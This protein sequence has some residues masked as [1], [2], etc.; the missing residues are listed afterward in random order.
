MSD[1]NF[2]FGDY[3]FNYYQQI[4]VEHESVSTTSEVQTY[5]GIL[6]QSQ[7]TPPGSFADNNYPLDLRQLVNIG[8]S[9]FK[10][11]YLT[12]VD[13]IDTDSSTE[14][15]IIGADNSSFTD[16]EIFL[17]LNPPNIL[18]ILHEVIHLKL[19]SYGFV[20]D[21]YNNIQLSDQ[22]NYN[23]SFLRYFNVFSEGVP[24]LILDLKTRLQIDRTLNS[25]SDSFEYGLINL[26]KIFDVYEQTEEFLDYFTTSAINRDGITKLLYVLTLSNLYFLTSQKDCGTQQKVHSNKHRN[27]KEEKINQKSFTNYLGIASSEKFLFTF[28]RTFL[29]L[30]FQ[31]ELNYLIKN[32]ILQEKEFPFNEYVNSNV[33]FVLNTFIHNLGLMGEQKKL[34]WLID[35]SC[36]LKSKIK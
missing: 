30:K 23:H 32:D 20:I 10:L 26:P 15:E 13:I 16:G 25:F 19:N 14:I 29:S 31:D 1:S 8:N 36:L 22:S 7:Y 34:S 24:G 2:I 17:N 9:I 35:R 4:S 27:F 18:H 12:G 21:H 3:I 11:I 33:K 28:F 6:D 5:K